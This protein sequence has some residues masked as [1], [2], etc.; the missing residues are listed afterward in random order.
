MARL[1]ISTFFVASFVLSGAFAGLL[2]DILPDIIPS[3]IIP[4]TKDA[5]KSQI[6][7]G[8]GMG[9]GQV[10]GAITWWTATVNSDPELA[11]ECKACCAAAANEIRGNVIA[12]ID[13]VA[14]SLVQKIDS[15]LSILVAAVYTEILGLLG[16]ANG[17]IAGIV[18][19]LEV[20]LDG[21]KQT[22]ILQTAN[23]SSTTVIA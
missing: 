18:N 15:T 22:C 5:A 11:P 16:G 4:V 2:P 10:N 8:A 19:D 3:G 9:K 21:A 23:V 6:W 12:E 17:L 7:R 14:D 13:G 20:S 1:I